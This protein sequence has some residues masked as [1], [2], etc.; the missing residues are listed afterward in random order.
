[1]LSPGT[2]GSHLPLDGESIPVGFAQSW[3]LW[4]DQKRAEA[5]Q[6]DMVGAAQSSARAAKSAAKW[7]AVAAFAAIAAAIGTWVQ[8]YVA[9][10]G[11]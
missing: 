10:P 2:F 9:W 3:L 6:E 1:M 4:H 11:R 8:A 7:A 5:V